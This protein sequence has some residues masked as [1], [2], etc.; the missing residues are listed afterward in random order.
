ME[1][2][3]IEIPL[4]KVKRHVILNFFKE[5]KNKIICKSCSH[6]V[7]SA[8]SENYNLQSHLKLHPELWNSYLHAVADAIETKVPK[9]SGIDSMKLVTLIIDKDEMEFSL[10]FPLSRIMRDVSNLNVQKAFDGLEGRIQADFNSSCVGP[11]MGPYDQ[12]ESLG[13]KSQLAES[14][15]DFERYTHFIHPEELDCRRFSIN[16]ALYGGLKDVEKIDAIQFED[17]NIDDQDDGSTGDQDDEEEHVVYTCQRQSCKIPCPC[18]PCSLDEKQCIEHKILHED[19]FDENEHVF[20]IRSEHEFCNDDSFF[21][22]MY[23]IKYPGIPRICKICNKDYLHHKCYHLKFHDNCKFCRKNRFKIYAETTSELRASIKKHEE[24]LKTVCPHCD[25]KFC[26]PYFRKKHVEFQHQENAPFGCDFCKT[27]FHSKQAK[28]YHESVH[29]GE[30]LP[31][32]ACT[33]CGKI[34]SAKVSLA[35]HM[36]YVHSEVRSFSCI[37]C[38]QRFKQKKDMRMHVLKVHG[39][40]ISKA[41]HGNLDNEES[42]PCDICGASFK[43]KKGLNEHIR[44]KHEG[45]SGAQAFKCD[46]CNLTYNQAKNLKAHQDL[47]H[48]SQPAEFACQVCG[49]IFNQKNNMRRHEKT[50]KK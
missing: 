42:F 46:L 45:P 7:N 32:E 17:E 4:L 35:N 48:S 23:L 33:K 43:Y 38:D 15:M 39:A 10:R 24:F 1:C 31:S 19:N 40:N 36:K 44:V 41:M 6:V 12:H 26:E 3:N 5:N 21:S 8:S 13:L 14:D 29:H 11:Y 37:A 18:A 27:K 9:S 20:A 30:K 47:K 34:F 22:Q 16:E 49:K 25:N 2:S 28:E 50:H